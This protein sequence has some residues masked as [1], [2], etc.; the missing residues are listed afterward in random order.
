MSKPNEELLDQVIRS[1]VMSAALYAKVQFDNAKDSE[2]LITAANEN[3]ELLVNA[4]KSKLSRYNEEL[5]LN[6][7]QEMLKDHKNE[8]IIR[9]DTDETVRVRV[10]VVEAKDGE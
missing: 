5:L 8:L 3:S 1:S 6:T 9:N 4:L 7:L 2:Q 10:E